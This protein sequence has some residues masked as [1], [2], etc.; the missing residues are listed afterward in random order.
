M[1]ISAPETASID[2][3]S[4]SASLDDVVRAQEW[5]RVAVLK[6]AQAI[7][8]DVLASAPA[9]A[10][11]LHLSGLLAG[12]NGQHDMAA[13]FLM[14]A[15]AQHPVTIQ[16][17][18]DLGDTL[19]HAGRFAE[20]A[21]I[22][23][24][25]IAIAPMLTSTYLK[26]S[27]TL[28]RQGHI[29]EALVV[30]EEAIRLEPD[31]ADVHVEN[32]NILQ[33]LNNTSK[34]LDAYERAL[35][36][37]PRFV[38]AHL[39]A[40][41]VQLRRGDWEAAATL[42]RSA[43]AC[44][45]DT[46]EAHVGLGVASLRLGQLDD[47]RDAFYAALTINPRHV[48]AARHLVLTLELLGR[49]SDV[50][51]AWCNLGAALAV[52][53]RFEE[54]AIAYR[55]A[56]TRKPN[57]LSALV[58]LGHL[59]LGTAR[60]REAIAMY[61][62]ALAIRP[63]HSRVHRGLGWA[64]LSVGDH[65]QGWND[66]ALDKSEPEK[67]Q[68]DFEQ[69]T[70]DGRPAMNDTILIW[71]DQ[72]LGDT[73]QFIRYAPLVKERCRE[74]VVECN[75]RLLP[76]LKRVRG[77]DRIIVRHAPLPAFDQQVTFHGLGR[78]FEQQGLTL[79]DAIPYLDIDADLLHHWRERVNASATTR[80]VGV[81]WGGEPER[82]DGRFRFMPLAA[83]APLGRV[84]RVRLISLQMGPPTIALL[85]PPQGLH[86]EELSG[87]S[88]TIADT[89]AVV[90]SLDL[91]ITVDTMMAHLAGA[92]GTPVWT[93]L[94]FS[95]DWRWE[96]RGETSRWYPTMRLFRQSRPGDWHGVVT[97]VREALEQLSSTSSASSEHQWA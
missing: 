58:R 45:N 89:A 9:D 76:L 69:P 38:A 57:C 63:D 11:A 13:A 72:G 96:L 86:I 55:E 85:A 93:L 14:R 27:R 60:P 26:L 47:A 24:R 39:G 8:H 50:V 94:S 71:A 87:S 25:A 84:P 44:A 97:R 54:A 79:A 36:H 34:A 62:R 16:R 68:R 67:K 33:I 2:E 29:R 31:R 65:A 75:A 41:R 92:L 81:V 5:Y 20:S 21:S 91:V 64:R 52:E 66:F 30:S 56:L 18:M 82:A 70:W 15:A 46:V 51:G 10:E 17:I 4:P 49:S 40:G 90:Q 7:C 28:V 78:I 12:R 23:L 59:Y 61:E 83:L 32:G 48:S 42:F 77:V 88:N 22:Y 95:P 1:A 19:N 74:V 6:E 3:P 35:Q 73:I 43:I 53:D 80:T 37:D